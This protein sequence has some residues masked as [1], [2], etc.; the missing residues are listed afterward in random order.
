MLLACL[1]PQGQ[2]F[3][4]MPWSSGKDLIAIPG[5]SGAMKIL[6]QSEILV[7]FHMKAVMEI[8]T[9]FFFF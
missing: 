4:M 6:V 3:L 5:Y 1:I 8:C 2:Y 7:Q 9:K